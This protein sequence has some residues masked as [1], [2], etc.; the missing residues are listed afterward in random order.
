MKGGAGRKARPFSMYK[1][2]IDD[3]KVLKKARSLRRVREQA[4]EKL[5]ELT[6]LKSPAL[7]GQADTPAYSI[8]GL[9]CYVSKKEAI[10]NELKRAIRMHET[11]KQRAYDIALCFDDIKQDFCIYHYIFGMSIEETA[12]MLDR[13]ERQTWRIRASIEGVLKDENTH[14]KTPVSKGMG[15]AIRR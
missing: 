4:E 7:H 8:G 13:S 5:N 10:E 11:A 14:E 6:I 1:I 12:K 9:E 2:T 3:A 15:E